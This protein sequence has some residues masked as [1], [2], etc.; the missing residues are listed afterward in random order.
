MKMIPMTAAALMTACLAGLAPGAPVLRFTFDEASGDALDTGAAPPASATFV[1]GATRSTDTPSGSGMS[2]D[3][4]SDSPY[5][6]LVGSDAAKLNDLPSLTLTT[7]LKVESY[8]S[9]PSNNKRLIAKQAS[10]ANFSGFSFN[11]NSTTNNLEPATPDNFRLG[12]FAGNA[13][14]FTSG[15][16]D[17]DVGASDWTFLALT[18]DP[19]AGELKFFVGDVATPVAQLGNTIFTVPGAGPVGGAG[20]RLA[21]GLT[22]A[23]STA[24]TSVTGWQDD[25]R[26]YGEALDLAALETVRLDN[27]AGGPTFAAGDFNS[28][29]IVDGDDLDIWIAGYGTMGTATRTTGDANGDQ[30]VDGADLLIWQRELGPTPP[31]AAIPEPGAAALAA[32]MALAGAMGRRRPGRTVGAAA[33]RDA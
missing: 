4:R 16:S 27:L 33:V 17:A 9:N 18:Y 7:W 20:A 23:A 2:L 14:I 29:G 11:M 30:N 8:P 31:A 19:T 24:D 5:A 28:D 12:F 26:V 10:D 13:T 3:L 1:G 22:D 32:W 21:V 15:F 6:Y 25:V